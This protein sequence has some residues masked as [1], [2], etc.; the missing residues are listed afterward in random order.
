MHTRF[1]IALATLMGAIAFALSASA[2]GWMRQTYAVDGFSVEFSGP[3]SVENVPLEADL[4]QSMVRATSY[5]QQSANYLFAIDANFYKGDLNFT[6]G[7]NAAL[8]VYKCTNVV[9]DTTPYLY[10]ADATR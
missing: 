1:L 2:A 6:G 3:V 10:R 7:A 9:S 8:G 4:L 5:R